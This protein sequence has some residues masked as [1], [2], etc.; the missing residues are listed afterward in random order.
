MQGVPLISNIV[1][2]GDGEFWLVDSNAIYGGLYHVETKTQMEQLPICRLKIGMICY[3]KEQD[4]YYKYLDH[5]WE[6]WILSDS[7]DNIIDEA[8]IQELCNIF[9]TNKDDAV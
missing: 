2:K 1:Q 9:N 6:P 4:M 7:N 8:E 3:V 5:A